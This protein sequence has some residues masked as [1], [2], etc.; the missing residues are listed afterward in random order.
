MQTV[1]R[2]VVVV[3]KVQQAKVTS[4]TIGCEDGSELVVGQDSPP[5]HVHSLL[6]GDYLIVDSK[7]ERH[8]VGKS[9]HEASLV[10]NGVP[11]TVAV[12]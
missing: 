8:V 4:I 6:I 11:Y 12:S 7:G 2:N 9:V 10:T 3:E 5:E 1:E